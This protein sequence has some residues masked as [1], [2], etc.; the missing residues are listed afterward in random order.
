VSLY[1]RFT[2]VKMQD[3]LLNESRNDFNSLFKS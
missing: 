1:I 3:Q 2:L